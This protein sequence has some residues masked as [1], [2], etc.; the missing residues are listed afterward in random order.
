M[1]DDSPGRREALELLSISD[2]VDNSLVVI[3]KHGFEALAVTTFVVRA[4]RLVRAIFH[5]LDEQLDVEAAILGRA[6][7]ETAVTL[8]WLG[9]DLP[10]NVKRWRLDDARER[11]KWLEELGALEKT[12]DEYAWPPWPERP[13][14]EAELRDLVASLEGKGVK[15]LPSFKDRCKTMSSHFYPTAYRQGSH[16]AVHP[17]PYALEQFIDHADEL[18]AH[19][20]ANGPRTRDKTYP[21][22]T[23]ALWLHLVLDVAAMTSNAFGWSREDIQ[24]ALDSIAAGLH[25]R[26]AE[27]E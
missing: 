11:L 25:A 13:M 26:G 7:M 18:G 6:L 20:L 12:G 5:L 14:E 3:Q 23:A 1:A 27:D 24:P 2:S 4:R 9:T 10:K 17:S 16:G 22:E 21:D 19:I 15:G 8:M